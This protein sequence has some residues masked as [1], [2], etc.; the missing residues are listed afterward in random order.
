ME[1]P[2][3]TAGMEWIGKPQLRDLVRRYGS[4]QSREARK[5]RHCD[6]PGRSDTER[7]LLIDESPGAALRIRRSSYNAFDLY[8][9]I[10]KAMNQI[11]A[12][13]A[14][15]EETSSAEGGIVAHPVLFGGLENMAEGDDLE[16]AS[17][18]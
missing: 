6:A 2:G 9:A 16:I 3:S 4:R 18:A 14:E 8:V 10:E 5:N 1:V 15:I 11:H 7:A 17:D 13:T 12:V